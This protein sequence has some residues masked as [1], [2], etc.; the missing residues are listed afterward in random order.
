MTGAIAIFVKTVGL[1][2]IKTRLAQGIGHTA[3]ETFHLL[4]AEAVAAVVRQVTAQYPLTP[5]W[6]VAE[7]QGSTAPAWQSFPQILQGAGE[8]GT[9]LA[10]V[11]NQL[12][13]RHR[14]V[15]LL[16]ADS[17]Q[18]RFRHLSQAAIW[19]EAGGFALGPAADGGF[20]LFGG[21][22]PIPRP[23]WESIPYSSCQT[24]K[25][26]IQAIAPLGNVQQLPT[27]LDVDTIQELKQLQTQLNHA[28]AR[29][30]PTNQTG[31]AE[32]LCPEQVA[33]LAWLNRLLSE[34]SD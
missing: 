9:R 34:I 22:Q 6:A 16:G 12:L 28:A 25:S 27:L 33:L 23:I 2:P 1:S 15:L 7:P 10:W 4:A 3:A 19:A 14:F 24:A 18:I 30:T 32:E 17:P 13:Q 11:Y 31:E 29:T 26:L 8:L 20:Y 21:S 5:Y